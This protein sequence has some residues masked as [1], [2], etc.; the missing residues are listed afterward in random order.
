MT[1]ECIYWLT[2]TDQNIFA[3]STRFAGK[4]KVLALGVYPDTSQLAEGIDPSNTRKEAKA[5]QRLTT[6]NEKRI[7]AG[8]S[9]IDSFVVWR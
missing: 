1:K 3:L 9:A 5:A 8:L 2:L 4:E 6:E 7:D